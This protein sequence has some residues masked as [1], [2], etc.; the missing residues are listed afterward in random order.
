MHMKKWTP[1]S[2]VDKEWYE[3]PVNYMSSACTTYQFINVLGVVKPFFAGGG[4]DVLALVMQHSKGRVPFS[5]S[6]FLW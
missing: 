5:F 2:H 4:E 3:Y 6:H 1:T